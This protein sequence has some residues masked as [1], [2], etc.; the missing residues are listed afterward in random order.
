[1]SSDD[2]EVVDLDE[3]E[4]EGP[5]ELIPGVTT[6]EAELRE[7]AR[8]DG[9]LYV[10]YV[11]RGPRDVVLSGPVRAGWGPGRYYRSRRVA[12]FAMAEKYGAERVKFLDGTTRGRWAYLIKNLKPES[13]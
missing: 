7:A 3:I 6:T 13:A 4:P 12:Y 2:D 5:A 1:M 10:N 9:E 11:V 8:P